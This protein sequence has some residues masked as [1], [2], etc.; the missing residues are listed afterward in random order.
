MGLPDL[1]LF[2][3]YHSID[4]AD[5]TMNALRYWYTQ[6]SDIV[7]LHALIVRCIARITKLLL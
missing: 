6:L 5:D 2:Q 1:S 7:Q 3:H 4:I